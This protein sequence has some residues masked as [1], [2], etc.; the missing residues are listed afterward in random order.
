MRTNWRQR[1]A[2]NPSG[3]PLGAAADGIAPAK[4]V[5]AVNVRIRND[6]RTKLLVGAPLLKLT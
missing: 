5:N 2:V 3:G 1:T 6:A 4:A